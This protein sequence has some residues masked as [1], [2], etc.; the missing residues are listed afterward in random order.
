MLW[1]E[2][3]VLLLLHVVCCDGWSTP[4]LVRHTASRLSAAAADGHPPNHIP[5]DHYGDFNEDS[6]ESE[7]N[8]GVDEIEGVDIINDD[9]SEDNASETQGVSKPPHW[10]T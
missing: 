9:T 3:V 8:Q 6:E 10:P 1:R 7:E 4:R 2:S 5:V